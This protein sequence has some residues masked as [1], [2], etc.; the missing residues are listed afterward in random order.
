LSSRVIDAN[1]IIRNI[2]KLLGRIIGEDIVFTINLYREPLTIFAD[3]SQLEQV[4]VNLATN[5]RDAMPDGGSLS[6]KTEKFEPNESIVNPISLDAGRYVQISVTDTGKGINSELK[7]RIFEPFFTTKDMGKGT[8]LGLSIVYGIVKQHNGEIT[9]YSEENEGTT[10][11]IFLPLVDLPAESE[12][13][14]SIPAPES[15]GGSETILIA[16]DDTSVRLYLKSILEQYG[17]TVIETSNGAEAVEEFIRN[18]D[19][20]DIIILDVVMPKLNGKEAYEIMSEV[21]AGIPVLFSSGYTAEII[22]S[23]GIME[24]EL[25]FISKPFSSHLLLSKIR[26]V[27]SFDAE[28]G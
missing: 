4:I 13:S 10:F 3:N 12:K 26:Q 6:I 7:E 19:I 5:A 17:Y 11:K 22:H 23:K 14:D 16:E 1:E 21:K 15:A 8:G 18:I 9:V 2:E 28:K 24:K 20:I 25:N 27:L